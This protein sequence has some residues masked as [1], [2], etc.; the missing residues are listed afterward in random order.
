M[1]WA[2][3]TADQAGAG[4]SLILLSRIPAQPSLPSN[5]TRIFIPKGESRGLQPQT[6]VHLTD[7]TEKTSLYFVS[8]VILNYEMADSHKYL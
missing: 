7:D 6:I 5:T 2:D 1:G 8:G 4:W 3:P